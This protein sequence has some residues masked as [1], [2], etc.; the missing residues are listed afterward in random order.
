MFASVSKSMSQ[1]AAVAILAMAPVALFAQ[2]APATRGRAHVDTVSKWDIFVGYS[3]LSPHAGVV[4]RTDRTPNL[5]GTYDPVNFGQIFSASYFANR[6][7]GVQAEVGVHEWGIQNSNP[8]GAYGTQSNNDGFTTL[9]GGLV[10]RYPTA[11]FTPFAHVNAGGALVDGP[12]ENPFTWGPSVA[13]GGGLDYRLSNHVSLRIIQADYEF[14]HVNFGATSGGTV[15][16]NSARLS[17]GLVFHTLTVVRPEKVELACSA[18]PVTVFPGDPVTVTA[19]ASGLNPKLNAVYMFSGSGVSSAGTTA[20]VATGSL[21]PG[22]YTV[23]C[24][25]KEGKEGKEGLKPWETASA[26]AVFTVKAFEPPTIKCTANPETIK[27]G[28]T[29]TITATGISPQNRPLTYS[30]MASIGTV[31]GNGTNVTFNS[32]GA[33][34]GTADITCN[35]AD[36]KGHTATANT[37]VTITIPYVA[38]VESPEV[39]QLE[40]RLSLHSVF[41]PTNLPTTGNPKGGLVASQEGTLIAL[42]KDFK[43]YLEFKPEA[44]LTLSGHADIRGSAAYNKA[45]S[46]RRVERTKSFLVEQGVPEDKIATVALGVQENLSAAQVK[47]LVEKNTELSAMEREKVLHELGV[48]VWAQNRRVDVTLSTTGQQSVRLYPF[49]AAD[50]MTLIGTKPAAP[51]KKAAGGAMKKPAPPVKKTAPPVKK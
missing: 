31:E 17:A 47:E 51:A 25:V 40:T 33:P 21:P 2:V 45:L 4:T 15:G 39:K 36:D 22:S 19:T 3:Y 23:Q 10:M 42:A 49:N 46:Q 1:F 34:T 38:P 29:S 27:P 11:T 26:T 8:P 6:Y 43:R 48:I 41:F 32:T 35:V 7:V 5:S 9:A 12:V 24:G 20:T 37:S 18:S 44:H 50:S 28:D 30:Y 13:V 16:I 14:M